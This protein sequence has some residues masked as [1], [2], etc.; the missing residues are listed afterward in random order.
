VTDNWILAA[1]LS[2]L[3]RRKRKQV[4]VGDQTVALFLINDRVFALRD[5]CIHEQ[6]SLSK[7][8]VLNGRVICPGHQWAFDPAT[9]W[10]EDQERCQPSYDVRVEEGKV[11]VDP[12]PLVRVPA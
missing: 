8:A 4:V 6:R 9:G 10:V 2:D 1:D 11:Y 3:A 7:G 5:V 12:Q